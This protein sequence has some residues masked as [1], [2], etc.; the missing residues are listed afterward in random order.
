MRKF[1][2]LVVLAS[3]TILCSPDANAQLGGLLKRTKA[4]AENALQKKAEDEAQK[5]IDQQV[6]KLVGE[7]WDEAADQFGKMLMSALPKAKTSV[8]LKKGLIRQEGREDIKIRNNDSKPT[9]SEYVRYLIVSTMNLPSQLAELSSMFGNGTVEEVW[10]RGDLKLTTDS[11]SGT[12][13]DATKEQFINLD[14][15]AEEYWT[16]DFGEMYDMASSAMINMNA[17][18]EEMSD[19]TLA[20]ATEQPTFEMESKVSVKKGKKKKIR[21]IQAQQ[22]IVIVEMVTKSEETDEEQ[23]KFYM[24]TD[25]WTAEKFG[26][27]E[28]IATYDKRLGEI[29]MQSITE[30]SMNANLDLSAFGD[31]RMAESLAEATEKLSEIKGTPIETNS[32]FVV[33]PADE[34]LD[35]E[36]VL[37][38]EEET[39]V[40]SFSG[41]S[42]EEPVVTQATMFSTTTFIS[43][44]ET[45]SFDLTIFD[46]PSTYS[47]IESPFKRYLKMTEEE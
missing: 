10:L 12:L 19:S 38:G 44:L 30:S 39:D 37:K 32:Y 42:Y 36:I 4:S 16:T 5:Q 9:D 33:G 24:I 28:T 7:L 40:R 13:T 20:E 47:E 25:I 43:N 14:H 15:S 21:G 6:E 26:G 1:I 22:H 18:I 27:S 34:K 11:E 29:M 17:Q 2:V 3:V 45:D 46:I 8:D 41:V 23:G 31:P 35:L